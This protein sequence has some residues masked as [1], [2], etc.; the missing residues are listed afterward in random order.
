MSAKNLFRCLVA[1]SLFC[2]LA[3]MAVTQVATDVPPVWK[4]LYEWH[5]NGGYWDEFTANR[6]LLLGLG[7]PFV[8]LVIAAQVGMFLFWRFARPAYAAVIAVMVL[9]TPFSGLV[10]QL[11]MEAAWWEL[12]AIVDGAIIALSYSQPFSS[13]FEHGST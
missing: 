12:S 7:I 8:I 9:C 5:G 1:I 11:P 13:Y 3:A 10:V 6:W 2:A 4:T